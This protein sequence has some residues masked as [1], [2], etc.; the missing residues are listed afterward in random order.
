MNSG[1]YWHNQSDDNFSVNKLLV[2]TRFPR[3]IAQPLFASGRSMKSEELQFRSYDNS[4]LGACLKLFDE[5]C[6][7]FFSKNEREDYL[8]FLRNRSEAYEVGLSDEKI[9]AAYG[10]SFDQQLNR[11]RISWIMVSPLSK[12]R[13]IGAGIMHR[14]KELAEVKGVGAIDIAASH[15]SAPFFGKFGAKELKSTT[16]GWGPNM[17]RID[18]ELVL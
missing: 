1:K 15:L 12:G 13:G 3:G 16:N 8:E 14:V 7:Q 5:N 17:H 11:G 10:M 9:V 6:P 18:M 2:L 4:C